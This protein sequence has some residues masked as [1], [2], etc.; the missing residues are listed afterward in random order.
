MLIFHVESAVL[1]ISAHSHCQCL[2]SAF[3]LL[4]ELTEVKALLS[5]EFP[6]RASDSKPVYVFIFGKVSD[7]SRRK[8]FVNLE[9]NPYLHLEAPKLV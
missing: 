7:M 9:P 6:L 1:Q 5:S 3:F 4:C 2:F 8:P